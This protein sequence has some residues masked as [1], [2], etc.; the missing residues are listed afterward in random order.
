MNIAVTFLPRQERAPLPPI[1][2]IGS[3]PNAVVV[4]PSLPAATIPEFVAL[5]KSRAGKLNYASPGIG[6]TPQLTM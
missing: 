3:T 4:H 6:T 1:G 2:F 5:A